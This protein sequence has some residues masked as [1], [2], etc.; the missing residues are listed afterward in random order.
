MPIV[1]QRRVGRAN[2]KESFREYWSIVF[3]VDLVLEP[4][5]G[6]CSLSERRFTPSTRNQQNSA[7]R[8]E[9]GRSASNTPK[10]HI[11]G[12]SRLRGPYIRTL[13]H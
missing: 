4:D 3:W 6:P 9:G 13:G 7:F 2:G 5:V 10:D 1:D 8:L 12:P 11:L